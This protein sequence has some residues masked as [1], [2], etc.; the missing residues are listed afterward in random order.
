MLDVVY[1][2]NEDLNDQVIHGFYQNKKIFLR[3]FFNT[4]QW[5]RHT[6]YD[7][8]QMILNAIKNKTIPGKQ[9]EDYQYH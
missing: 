5:K 8:R 6:P 3:T 4:Y 9:Q 2:E 7:G 1:V